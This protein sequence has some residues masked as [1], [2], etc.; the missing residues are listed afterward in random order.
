MNALLPLD[1]M[2]TE[3]KL[4]AVETIWDDLCRNENQI[5]V[6]DWQK[7]LLDERQRQVAIGQAKYDDWET[8]KQRIRT[9]TS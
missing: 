3:E 6:T 9:R 4:R 7:E 1:K 5:P 8:A 2:T